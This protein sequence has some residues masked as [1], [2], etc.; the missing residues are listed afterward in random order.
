MLAL[1]LGRERDWGEM[2]FFYSSSPLRPPFSVPVS[3]LA[4]Q[5]P[6][7]RLRPLLLPPGARVLNGFSLSPS[8]PDQ[9]SSQARRW[10]IS[11]GGA[12]P[13]KF[14]KITPF[15]K[16]PPYL[17]T[18]IFAMGG[19]MA[20][21]APPQRRACLQRQNLNYPLINKSK[22]RIQTISGPGCSKNEHLWRSE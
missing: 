12:E 22:D 2:S 15:C 14:P 21:L 5:F 16:G 9:T 20:P 3:S 11:M 17:H 18:K 13:P 8:S 4:R 19:A 10:Q 6:E 7:S 1:W